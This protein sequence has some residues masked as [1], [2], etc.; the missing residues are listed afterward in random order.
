MSGLYFLSFSESRGTQ[1]VELILPLRWMTFYEEVCRVATWSSLSTF[2]RD[3]KINVYNFTDAAFGRRV[4]QTVL[5]NDDDI[6]PKIYGHCSGRSH[7][8]SSA[9]EG[10]RPLAI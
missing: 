9:S 3:Y 10:E 4:L 6:L 2:I 7:K 5:V 1:Q 8:I